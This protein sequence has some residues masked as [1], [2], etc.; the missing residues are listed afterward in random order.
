M[1]A[2]GPGTLAP[3]CS[4]HRGQQSGG[5]PVR[6]LTPPW[7]ARGHPEFLMGS[8]PLPCPGSGEGCL[9]RA[10]APPPKGRLRPLSIC[11]GSKS[12]SHL[13][14]LLYSRS[15]PP[16]SLPPHCRLP[17]P[18]DLPCVPPPLHGAAPP[19]ARSR[20]C[21]PA[22]VPFRTTFCGASPPL[23]PESVLVCVTHC[24]THWEGGS[25]RA[26]TLPWW[27]PDVSQGPKTAPGT[28]EKLHEQSWTGWGV[29][30]QCTWWDTIHGTDYPRVPR[31]FLSVYHRDLSVW[32]QGK[33]TARAP[34]QGCL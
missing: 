18:L 31:S 1:T 30:V 19:H 33:K 26:G 13:S 28:W 14:C 22:P 9:V 20:S 34:A 16:G 11:H 27:A 8:Q 15:G 24:V 23:T 12:A 17:E 3:G 29:D 10:P 4:Q 2:R 32:K 21:P 6:D 5:C 25:F 7:V